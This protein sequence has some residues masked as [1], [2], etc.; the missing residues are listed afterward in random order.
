VRR[1]LDRAATRQAAEFDPT[2]FV[3]DADTMVIDEVQR[4][5]ELFLAI[6]ETVE[7]LSRPA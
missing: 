7:A 3:A 1:S 4:V 5:P 2:E 6:K